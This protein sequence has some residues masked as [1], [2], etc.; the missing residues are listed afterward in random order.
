MTTLFDVPVRHA[1]EAGG[2]DSLESIPGLLKRL[3]ILAPGSLKSL[4][5]PLCLHVMPSS[6]GPALSKAWNIEEEIFL[7]SLKILRGLP[8][9]CI[10]I[11][12]FILLA[13]VLSPKVPGSDLTLRRWK[14][15]QTTPFRKNWPYFIR[16][17]RHLASSI[18]FPRYDKTLS[19]FGAAEDSI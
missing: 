13:Y 9:K 12:R 7:G 11:R 15:F 16:I 18:S 2:I 19:I 8:G 6:S 3:Q 17:S 5:Y 4:K 14:K 1:T 10:V